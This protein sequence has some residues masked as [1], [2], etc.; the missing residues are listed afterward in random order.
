M[1]TLTIPQHFVNLREISD[2]VEDYISRQTYVLEYGQDDYTADNILN[3]C[4]EIIYEELNEYG[5]V[6]DTDWRNDRFTCGY[7]YLLRKF[8]DDLPNLIRPVKSD[9][10]NYLNSSETEDELNDIYE[11]IQPTGDYKELPYILSSTYVTDNKFLDYVKSIIANLNDELTPVK[12]PS[13]DKAKEYIVK[14]GKLRELAT[15][16]SRI[17]ISNLPELTVDTN[18]VDKMLRDYDTDK[19]S[20]DLISIYSKVDT[21]NVP[22]Y[23]SDLKDKYMQEHH[24]RAAHHIEYYTDPKKSPLPLITTE[25][26]I[27]MVAHH[28]EIDTTKSEFAESVEDM[29]AKGRSV[30]RDDHIS[31]IRKMKDII[32][33]NMEDE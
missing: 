14:T 33:L 11:Y 4:Y 18:I 2:A 6:V 16:Y 23:L 24:E 31:L 21:D 19:I 17:L 26:L 28:V 30:L 3:T 13:I 12:I 25:A 9:I 10:E 7:I 8:I 1:Y 27:L 5:L 22:E 32:L 15:K 29:I 20:P